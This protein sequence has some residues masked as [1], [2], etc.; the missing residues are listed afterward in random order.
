MARYCQNCGKEVNENAYVCLNCGA[1]LAEFKTN[2]NSNSK[3]KLAA[4]LLA[5]FLGW[6]GVHNFYLGYNGKGIAQLLLSLLS[7]GLLSF[8]TGLWGFTE[9]KLILVG[10]INVDANGVPLKD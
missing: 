8:I 4:G 6:L 7:F 3:S 9:G 2:T 10:S 5:I 1:K